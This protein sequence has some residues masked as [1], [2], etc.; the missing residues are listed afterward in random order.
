MK[1]MHIAILTLA[2]ATRLA[3]AQGTGPTGGL[4]ITQ[5]DTARLLSSQETRLYV[6]APG[7][8]PGASPDSLA[9]YESLDGDSW[10]RR[11]VRAVTRAPNEDAGISFY[12]LLDNS[13]SMWTETTETGKARIADARAAAGEFL[14][15]LGPKDRVGLA[16][17]NTRYWEAGKPGGAA[18]DAARALEEIGRPSEA[19]A[20]TELYLSLERGLEALAAEP[21]R[22]VLIALSDGEDFPFSR[23]TGRPN[24]DSGLRSSGP[25]AVIDR[26]SR[27]GVTVYAI[28]FG[29][30]RDQRL[31]SIAADTGGRAFDAMDGL[32]LAEVYE[33]VRTDVLAEL[34]VDY[35]AGMAAGEERLVRVEAETPG[36]RLASPVR[37][38]YAGTLF[39]GSAERPV[40]YL[41]LLTAA[42]FAAWGALVLL[43]LERPTDRAGIRLLYGPSGR[44]GRGT[45]FFELAG[46]RTVVGS[47]AAAG[48]TLAGN[49]SIRSEHAAIVRDEAKGTYTL[50]ADSPVTVNNRPA[51]RRRLES[52]DV[53]NLAGTVVVFEEEPSRPSP[54]RDS[55]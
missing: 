49:P 18:A 54:S 37:R 24:P 23:R 46:T 1:R 30:E 8:E 39:G 15:S 6:S 7:L 11:P 29:S 17:F 25:S 45:R 10:E 12:L 50:V 33:T 3:L 4:S 32:E 34:A 47:G 26:A 42:A 22:R 31:G 55:R 13:G 44:A 36:A 52:G 14:R 5:I 2:C 27:D 51:S 40:P 19:D 41:F 35:R 38:Y 28:R 16:V 53:I 20:F 48:I 43:R 9:V 21:G